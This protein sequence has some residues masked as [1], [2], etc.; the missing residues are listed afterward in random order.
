MSARK[1]II[2]AIA[3][4]SAFIIIALSAYNKKTA[5]IKYAR[6]LIGTVVEII[7]VG[8]DEARLNMA[9]EA[10]FAEIKRLEG[11]MSHYKE[12]SDVSRINEASGKEAVTISKEAL[13]VIESSI[14]VS[15]ISNGAF[16][17]T[18]GVLGKAWHFTKDDKGEF[19]PP[20]PEEVKKLLPLVDYRGIIIDKKNS[21]VKLAKQGM[22]INLGGIA[23]GYIVGKAIETLKGHGIKKGIVHAGGDMVVFQ[24]PNDLPWNI[25]IQNP[26]DKDKIIG[27]LKVSNAAISTSGDYERFFI[28][29]GVRYHHIIDPSTGFPANKS[30]AVTILAKEPMF[31]DALSTAIFV[32][33]PDIGMELIKRLPDVEGLIIDAD[34]KM[35]ISPGLKEKVNFL[36]Q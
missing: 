36:K 7:L 8:K 20:S 17:V 30:R 11:L 16:D 34:G 5:E 27:T 19:T 14:Y 15:Q 3:T 33:G 29:N 23:K 31:A 21:T 4:V 18:M 25:G 1:K 10:A 12:G 2:A 13:D 6:N 28:K 9:A 22:R 24:E 32:M 26:R 35:T